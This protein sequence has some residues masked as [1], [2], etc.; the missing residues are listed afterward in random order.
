MAN[1]LKHFFCVPPSLSDRLLSTAVFVVFTLVGH[2]QAPIS[3]TV[4]GQCYELCKSFS[5]TQQLRAII[6]HFL[7][8]Y[9]IALLNV[10]AY[11]HLQA[12]TAVEVETIDHTFSIVTSVLISCKQ[13]T[14]CLPSIAC[15]HTGYLENAVPTRD[16]QATAFCSKY[17]HIGKCM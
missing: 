11:T 10:K 3:H 4:V 5:I 1:K 14:K 8:V 13:G 9:I 12:V 15:V 16:P 7:V 2:I 6:Y 17:L